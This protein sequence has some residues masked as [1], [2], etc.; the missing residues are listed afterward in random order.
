MKLIDA[1]HKKFVPSVLKVNASD[2]H[3]AKFKYY[4]L[5]ISYYQSVLMHHFYFISR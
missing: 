4:G 1:L 2:D 3:G 5:P